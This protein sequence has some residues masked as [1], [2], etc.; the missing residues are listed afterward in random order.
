MSNLTL[1]T[2]YYDIGRENWTSF[3]RSVSDYMSYFSQIS[4][5]NANMVIYC[6][7]K[8]YETINRIRPENEQTKIIVV[9]F[10]KLEFYQLFFQQI[11][12]TMISQ[13][14]KQSIIYHNIPEMLYPEYNIIN[15]NK[16]C[17]VKESLNYFNTQNYGWVD[18]GYNHGNKLNIPN[19]LSFIDELTQN[20]K[21][22]MHCLKEPSDDML[23]N[24]IYYFNNDVRITGGAFFGTKISIQE[25][26]KLIKFVI[27]NSLKLHLIDDDQTIYNMAYLQNK[28]LFNLKQ[29]S[30]FSHFSIK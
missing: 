4:Q 11:K 18:F 22:H 19:D 9:S 17:F 21:I 14:F 2:A 27:Q 15:L 23:Y 30:F 13:F 3:R 5:I 26:Y 12:D 7:Q 16:V 6:D 10:D 25:F 1:A 8:H 29:G 20:N 24:P 28:F